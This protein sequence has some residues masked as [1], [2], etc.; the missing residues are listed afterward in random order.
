MQLFF[1]SGYHNVMRELEQQ[2]KNEADKE[3]GDEEQ[4][5]ITV[6]EL[7]K[8]LLVTIQIICYDINLN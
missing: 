3:K 2:V 4:K 6:E 8:K 5:N 1:K 7:V